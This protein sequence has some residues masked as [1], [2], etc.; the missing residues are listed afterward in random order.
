MG[1]WVMWVCLLFVSSRFRFRFRAS[2][3]VTGAVVMARCAGPLD[4]MYEAFGA[5]GR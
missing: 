5:V 1:V 4:W 2:T 3:E